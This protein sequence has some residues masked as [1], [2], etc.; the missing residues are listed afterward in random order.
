M[1]KDVEYPVEVIAFI[2]GVTR[3]RIRQYVKEGLPKSTRN[4]YP[5]ALCV[6]WVIEF[7]KKR[8]VV[9]DNAIKQHK[10][11]LLKANADKVER[12]NKTATKELIPAEQV[13]RDAERAARIVKEKV[14]SWP[15]RV[16][17]LVAVEPD[18]FKCDQ[19]LRQEC[20]QLLDE[21]A[22]EVLR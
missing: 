2:F 10:K 21:I 13:K 19:I 9:T 15:G 3:S 7:W 12:E 22:K 20:N 1:I 5:L 16:A 8:A 6:Q 14:T 4:S 17:A 11:R 18:P